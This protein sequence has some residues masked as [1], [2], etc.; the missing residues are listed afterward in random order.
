VLK[1]TR[2]HS[3]DK[4]ARS[5]KGLIPKTNRER[6]VCEQGKAD[7]NNMSRL[8]FVYA[9]LLGCVWAS[10]TMKNALRGDVVRETKIFAAPVGLK[11]TNFCI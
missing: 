9:I 1:S 10:N 7:F 4:V 3:I 11:N 2:C 8:T 6:R 5:K